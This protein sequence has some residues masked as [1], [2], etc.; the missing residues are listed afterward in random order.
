MTT[1][2]NGAFYQC[3][4]LKSITIPNNV[5]SIDDRAF[6]NCT[7][8]TTVNFNAENCTK[9]GS[10]SYRVFENCTNLTTVNIGDA[11]KKIPSYAFYEC[12]GLKSIAIPNSVTLIGKRAFYGCDRSTELIIGNS[13]TSIGDGAFGRCSKLTEIT[14]PEN[15]T[16]MGYG[17]FYGC[18]ES[19]TVNFNA[20][21]C[22]SSGYI[23]TSSF[24][25]TFDTINIGENVELIPDR[26]FVSE[27]STKNIN[28]NAINCS[29]NGSNTIFNFRDL[30][31]FTFGDKVET[32]PT[33]LCLQLP[34]STITLP[35]SLKDIGVMA[36]A[37]SALTEIFI[38]DNVFHIQDK[39]FWHC[40]DLR[41]VK[42]PCDLNYY[43]T[44]VIIDNSAFGYEEATADGKVMNITSVY[45]KSPNDI[46][47]KLNFYNEQANPMYTG[48]ILYKDSNEIVTHVS[49]DNYDMSDNSDVNRG[50]YAFTGCISIQTCEFN[51]GDWDKSY[52]LPEGIFKNCVNLNSFDIGRY[53]NMKSIGSGAFCGCS[54]LTSV[55]IPNSV[56]SIGN[57][58]FTSCS[59][60]TS[61]TIPDGVTEIKDYTFDGCT[62]LTEVT[63]P[64]SVT[65]IG[66]YAFQNNRN[67]KLSD[68]SVTNNITFIGQ[69]AFAGTGIENIELNS[70]TTIGINA[71]LLSALNTITLGG[72]IS[73]L[74]SGS[75]TCPNLYEIVINRESAP[76]TTGNPFKVEDV[77]VGSAVEGSKYLR[78]PSNATGYDSADGYWVETLQNEAGF[79]VVNINS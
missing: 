32:I 4:Q 19:I 25:I 48:A 10:S 29:Y 64:S 8:L 74:S 60:L 40:F 43:N 57:N 26:L 2:K 55:T 61:I 54:G 36:F 75:L 38:P 46:P 72:N 7:G 18:P 37:H 35:E 39:A 73:I 59:K 62:G 44:P 20:R 66:N 69:S 5:T 76:V 67:I 21:N 13:V 49:L 31:S 3:T 23:F 22:T 58:A 14:I 45:Y 65:K 33:G 16:S 15:V 51:S 28:F 6:S 50:K 47:R 63:I 77:L 78:I 53:T 27:I 11:V 30:E 41:K 12:N 68:L 9:M 24:V 34:L 42:L 17:A 56:T 79:N 71:F 1:I 52:D 70:V